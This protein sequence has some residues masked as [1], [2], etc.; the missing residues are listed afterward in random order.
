MFYGQ[1]PLRVYARPAGTMEIWFG[2]LILLVLGVPLARAILR[3]NELFCVELRGGGLSVVR[4]RL[5]QR[6][7]DELFDVLRRGR[8]RDARL[9]VVTEEGHPRLMVVGG[10]IPDDTLQALRN[11]VGTY[12]AQ[13]IRAGRRVR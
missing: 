7:F 1:Q 5:P 6:L 3:H 4:G 2:L 9:K 10:D 12:R 11:V 8:V 13:Q